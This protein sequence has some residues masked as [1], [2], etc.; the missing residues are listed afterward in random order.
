M[1]YLSFTFFA[2][3]CLKRVAPIH[4]TNTC[5]FSTVLF[6]ARCAFSLHKHLSFFHCIECLNRTVQ[7]RWKKDTTFSDIYV[8]RYSSSFSSSMPFK[9]RKFENKHSSIWKQKK[10][11]KNLLIFKYVFSILSHFTKK[12]E[13]LRNFPKKSFFSFSFLSHLSCNFAKRK[14]ATKLRSVEK[15]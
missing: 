11:K 3:T 10:K 9:K 12:C 14:V 4:Y 1:S 13:K 5:H 7:K 6:E 2:P 8:F 15:R